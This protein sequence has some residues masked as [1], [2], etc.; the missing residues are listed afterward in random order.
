MKNNIS[1]AVESMMKATVEASNQ[2]NQPLKVVARS[3][4]LSHF[5]QVSFLI[6]LIEGAY[7]E[8]TFTKDFYCDVGTAVHSVLQKWFGLTGNLYGLWKCPVCDKIIKEGFGPVYHKPCNSICIYDE[9]SLNYKELTGHCDGIVIVDNKCYILEFKTI[10][11]KGLNDRILKNEPI[12][13]HSNQINM[14]VLMAQKLQLPYPLVGAVI[15][16]IARDN[17]SKYAAF[18]QGGV[19]ISDV[20]NTLEQ[21]RDAVK[22]LKSGTFTNVIKKC[23]SFRDAN[24]CPYK[25]ICFRGNIEDTLAAY[26]STYNG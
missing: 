17:P 5:C 14:Y 19:S 10:S 9:Y 6:P 26:W 7:E 2:L 11:L 1:I 25:S 24:F 12:D 13:Y 22:M 18:F 3:S 21:Y 20:K 16:Y 4:T 15:I 8:E 23:A